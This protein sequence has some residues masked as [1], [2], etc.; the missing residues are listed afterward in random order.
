MTRAL[1]LSLYHQPDPGIVRDRH[2]L[3]WLWRLVVWAACPHRAI[4]LLLT[5][6]P[7]DFRVAETSLL[8]HPAL[9]SRSTYATSSRSGLGRAMVGRLLRATRLP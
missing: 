4:V 9:S 7:I 1:A 6:E 5:G 2:G 3:L 8:L